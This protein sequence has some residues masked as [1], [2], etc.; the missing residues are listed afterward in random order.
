MN[1]KY[2]LKLNN[3]T[4]F[5]DVNKSWLL[6]LNRYLGTLFW[7]LLMNFHWL[8]ITGSLFYRYLKKKKWFWRLKYFL[9]FLVII[10]CTV[11]GI[12]ESR[13]ESKN[14]FTSFMMEV[15]IMQ[16]SVHW[17]NLVGKSKDWFLYYMDIRHERVKVAVGER[18]KVT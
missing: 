15:P 14:R 4:T 3:K 5:L 18:V 7:Q 1:G 11:N 10:F 9:R 2:I 6:H 16:K 13:L 8:L 12:T 17:I